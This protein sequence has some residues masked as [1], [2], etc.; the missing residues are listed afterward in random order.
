MD[1]KLWWYTQRVAIIAAATIAAQI[2]V[3]W[4]AS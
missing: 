2:L 1:E 3:V 4:L